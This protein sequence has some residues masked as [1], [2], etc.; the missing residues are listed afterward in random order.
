MWTLTRCLP[1]WPLGR[2][3]SHRPAPVV[4]PPPPPLVPRR[5]CGGLAVMNTA[6]FYPRKTR[7]MHNPAPRTS[8]DLRRHSAA[9]PPTELRRS[10]RKR[11][12][13][14]RNSGALVL[15]HRKRPKLP[16]ADAPTRSD[17]RPTYFDHPDTPPRRPRQNCGAPIENATEI[18]EIAALYVP[19]SFRQL[20]TICGP[21]IAHF[22]SFPLIIS[23]LS[24]PVAAPP[25]LHRSTLRFIFCL[26]VFNCVPSRPSYFQLFKLFL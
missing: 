4:L 26:F 3:G 20:P 22:R 12:R 9:A 2:R 15:R 13:N 24:P 19:D 1:T 16:K 17:T 18:I 5:H 10:H 11:D 23:T 6:Q 7:F 14:H 8:R 21:I 25:T